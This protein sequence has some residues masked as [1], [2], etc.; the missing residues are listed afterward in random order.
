MN[1]MYGRHWRYHPE[2]ERLSRYYGILLDSLASSN[3]LRQDGISYQLAPQGPATLATYEEDNRKHRDQVR[4]QKLLGFLTLWLVI[5]GL[6]QA[7]LNL[8]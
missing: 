4:Q 1:Q 7:Y 6:L 8:K 2:N 3:D 5:V